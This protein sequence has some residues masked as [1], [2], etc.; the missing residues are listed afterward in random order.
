M[1]HLRKKTMHKLIVWLIFV[2]IGA[3][4]FAQSSY[5]YTDIF[6]LQ[7]PDNDLSI[8][9]LQMLFGQVGTSL[10]VTS[11][12]PPENPVIGNLFMIFNT[13]VLT[14]LMLLVMYSIFF[15]AINVSQ[16]GSQGMSKQSSAFL[17][18]RI[19]LGSSLLLPAFNSGYSG[20]QVMVMNIVVYGVA[21]ANYAWTQTYQIAMGEESGSAS[22]TS[23]LTEYDMFP[24]GLANTWSATTTKAMTFDSGNTSRCQKPDTAL[25]TATDIFTMALCTQL[26]A[27]QATMGGLDGVYST[28]NQT[29]DMTDP[30]D[31]KC[32][33][34]TGYYTCFGNI[35]GTSSTYKATLCGSIKFGD[36]EQ[37]GAIQ[38]AVTTAM[39]QAAGYA[40]NAA[41]ENVY[42]D[43]NG[44]LTTAGKQ[45]FDCSGMVSLSPTPT[46]DNYVDAGQGLANCA[47][48]SVIASIAENYAEGLMSS[49]PVSG[50]SSNASSDDNYKSGWATAGQYFQTLSL[51]IAS[52]N[53][54]TGASS[55]SAESAAATL[56]DKRGKLVK[57]NFSD[58]DASSACTDNSGFA[59]TPACTQ[60]CICLDITTDSGTNKY[61]TYFYDAVLPYIQ[62]SQTTYNYYSSAATTVVA[63]SAKSI[64]D[65][66]ATTQSSGVTDTTSSVQNI[67]ACQIA[68]S[69]ASASLELNSDMP[70]YLQTSNVMQ[71]GNL[72][73]LTGNASG[74]NLTAGVVAPAKIDFAT[75]NMMLSVNMV[76]EALTG[77]KLF[78]SPITSTSDYQSYSKSSNTCPNCNAIASKASDCSNN[79]STFLNNIQNYLVMGSSED[80]A[81]TAKAGLFGM[82]YIEEQGW[83]KFADPLAN[84]TNLGVT[85]IASGV[86]Y[87]VSTMQQLFDAMLEISLAY[88]SYVAI[89]KLGLAL[90]N[91]GTSGYMEPV[92]VSIGALVEG[93]FQMLF[94]LDKFALE[95]F[96]PL[97]TA[98]AGIL[99][100]QGVV[101][102]VFLPFLA[103]IIYLFGVLGWLF[104]VIEAMVASALV[105]MGLTHPE[106]HD[107]LGQTEQALMLLLSVFVRPVTMIIGLFFAISV[108]QATMNL[109]NT[110][111]LYVMSDYFNSTFVNGGYGTNV[112]STYSKVV[113]VSS[114]G[115]LLVYTYIAYSILEMCYGLISQIPDRI[116]R[117]I[118]G[119]ESQ[120]Q[121]TQMAGK[122]K[123][124][125]QGAAQQG[126]KGAGDSTRAPQVSSV[127]PGINV[128]G[129]QAARQDKKKKGGG[130][131]VTPTPPAE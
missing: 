122:I 69:I 27:K 66:M 14:M 65:E 46:W 55:S 96:I 100:V 102:G 16:D 41:T 6:T 52:G 24:F 54:S 43:E 118:G 19:V 53:V 34:T 98:I 127:S 40:A 44:A 129:A 76:L 30:G 113:T 3:S 115:V 114:L 62:N 51:N 81:N 72:G 82:T 89:A 87:Y 2:G 116:L 61:L 75:T 39:G 63:Q 124:D 104:A 1:I 103:T 32:S 25:V 35:Q 31:M 125:T 97:G 93:I 49:F 95:L 47:I 22:E 38:G 59:N 110:G 121:A 74:F 83:S 13:G 84:L 28:Y 21:F 111:F 36:E 64:N 88:T 119:P 91:A 117:W 26:Y 11:T 131:G 130:G 7:Y 17:T 70:A 90:A 94:A 60:K 5:T 12:P 58:A 37:Q 101:L 9:M 79:G 80:S 42:V 112:G 123:Q 45:I 106:G 57:Y 120:S 128:A 107:L 99:F 33:N 105:S 85:M 50:S 20:I 92:L 67:A 15:Q 4:A 8:K 48:R 78:P 73:A 71:P 108:S 18:F 56:L 77:M 109:V 68:G 23:E 10:N 29:A 126:S 86:F